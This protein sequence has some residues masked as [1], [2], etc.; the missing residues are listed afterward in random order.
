[1]NRKTLWV[2]PTFFLFVLAIWAADV[3]GKW[4]AQVPGR[5]GQMREVT[6]TLKASG[7]TLTGTVSGRNG[8]VP[9]ADGKVTGEDISFSVTQDFGGNSVTQKYT[10]KVAGGEIKFKRAGGQGEPIEFV[11]KRAATT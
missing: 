9:I 2:I 3:S 7:E 6:F 4:T 10:G 5:S 11:A 8:D 1:M